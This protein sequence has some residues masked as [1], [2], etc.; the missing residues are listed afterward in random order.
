[1]RSFPRQDASGFSI[2]L[3]SIIPH[4]RRCNGMKRIAWLTLLV[5][6]LLVSAAS[7]AYV[8]IN[9]PKEVSIGDPI[10]VNGTTI[11]GGL[12]KPS[13]SPGFSTDVILYSVKSTKSE[14][15]RKTI[16]VQEDGLFSTTFETGGLT[17][18]DYT[19]EIIDPEPPNT[20][21]GS[22]KTLQFLKLVDR[23][24]DVRITSPLVRDFDGSLDIAGTID[25][26]GNAGVRI[27]IES[28]GAIVY[29][30]E[31]I[32]TDPNGAFAATVPIQSTGTYRVTFRDTKGYIG[33]FTFVV[34]GGPAPAETET[35]VVSAS[36]PATRSAPAYFEVDTRVGLV[37]LTTSSGGIDWVIEYI[38]E[39]GRLRKI[40]DAGLL[41]PEI[42]EFSAQGGRVY[43]KIYPTG[44]SDHGT[45]QLS[46]TNADAVR[47]SQNAPV[48]FGDAT[49]TP[50]EAATPLP[51]V[52][53][54]FAVLVVILSRR[55]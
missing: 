45:V 55:G 51:A 48:I 23:S 1:M 37:T 21:G 33:T 53:A 42:V 19:I 24:G 40:N 46:A 13:L 36:A 34:T 7:A 27:E 17:A 16:V 39:G 15:G 5:A 30:P 12:T 8:E 29:G 4:I 35:A 52:L 38:D 44:Y 47:A 11:V 20:F 26:I 2:D 50:A 22:S 3:D 18:G 6:M 9:A 31:Y 28:G 14:V 41:D 25:K 54:L 43:V 10:K 49:P 32:R